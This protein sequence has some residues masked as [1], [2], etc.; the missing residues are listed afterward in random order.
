MDDP[1]HFFRHFFCTEEMEFLARLH[2]FKT[3]PHVFE[4]PSTVFAV[5]YI[6]SCFFSHNGRGKFINHS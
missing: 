4:T 2:V 1:I 5:V 6:N 3:C